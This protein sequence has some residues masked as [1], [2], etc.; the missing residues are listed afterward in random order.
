MH[1][2]RASEKKEGV[3]EI[4][5]ERSER[6]REF[7]EKIGLGFLYF[8]YVMLNHCILLKTVIFVL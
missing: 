8:P 4:N 2:K 5:R 7:M 6:D 1:K 3:C